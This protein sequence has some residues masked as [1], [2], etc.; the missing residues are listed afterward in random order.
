MNRR[1]FVEAICLGA[2]TTGL[3]GFSN[4]APP[5]SPM[6]EMTSTHQTVLPELVQVPVSVEGVRQPVIDLAGKWQ[7]APDP[8]K[9]FWAH[10]LDRTA[11]TRIT[12]PG[13]FATQGF[14]VAANSEYPS[15]TRISIP[16]DFAGQRILL[17][18]DGV[19][20]RARV[21]VNGSFVRS[22]DGGFTSWTCDITDFAKPGEAAELVVGI[23]DRSDDISQASYYAKHSVA[24]ILRGVRLFAIP[25]DHLT[26]IALTVGLDREYR[27]GRLSITPAVARRTKRPLQLAVRLQDAQGRDIALRQNAFDLNAGNPGPFELSIDNP[28]KW[29]AEH[30]YLYVLDVSLR[31]GT[32]DLMTVRKSIGFR[33][34]ERSGSSLLINGQE[35]KLRGV[36]RHSIHPVYGRTVP[37]D[38]D[39]KDAVLFRQANMNFVRTSH[40]PPSEEFLD[41]CDRH[42]IYVEEET[43]VCWSKCD[44]GPSSDPAFAERFR[45]QWEEMIERDRSHPSVIFWSLGNESQW[46]SNFVLESQCAR[47]LDPSRPTIFS[48]PETVAWEAS[49]FD[50]YSR[51]YAEVNADLS[52]SEFPVL[53]DEFAHV[54]CY[55]IDTLRS[56]SGV[57]NYWGHSIKRFGDRFLASDGC[58]G[59]SIWAGIDEVFLLPEG[60]VGY[61]PWGVIDGWRRPKPEY[62]LTKKAYSPIRIEDG[63]LSVPP[64]GEP[65]RIPVGNAF[66]HTNFSELAIRWSVGSESGKVRN[67]DISPRKRGILNIPP[68]SW[69][70]GETVY[71]QFSRADG[72]LID[73]FNL[74]LDKRRFIFAGPQGPAPQLTENANEISVAG[75][76]FAIG[77]SKQSGLLIHATYRDQKL[78]E[79][80]PFLNLGRGPV[81]RWWLKKLDVRR[82]QD[83]VL[84][85]VS[86]EHIWDGQND[87]IAL[88]YEIAMDGTGLI[89]TTYRTPDKPYNMLGLTYLLPENVDQLTWDRQALWSAYPADHIGR[90]SGVAKK[91]AAHAALRYGEEPTWPWS[92]DTADFFLFGK[93]QPPGATND[94]RSL[95][96]NIWHASCV[97]SGNNARV[98]AESAGDAAVQADVR[99]DGKVLFTIYNCWS[100]P[101]LEWGNYTGVVGQSAESIHSVAIRLT[102]SDEGYKTEF[103]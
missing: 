73:E 23:T 7:F 87:S 33:T 8:V 95:K 67:L 37:S 48:Y 65:L 19:Y 51:H 80:G 54:S 97:L 56:N 29:D 74:P 15:Y 75:S 77:L 9:E 98:R 88:D 43:A 26:R 57:R 62:W 94:F 21:W 100:Y 34:V 35:I 71:L 22:H 101:D 53:N 92:E 91:Q 49:G 31:S 32:A 10:R 102:S 47:E 85:R 24:G 25:Q 50:I 27:N 84:L 61:G 70:S 82:T 2:A 12:V 40:Y 66:D 41:A 14:S 90:A 79:G 45:G 63:A 72:N 5:L 4:S 20:S 17:C 96:E 52:S 30:P 60:P 39:E 59:G 6:N 64:K 28:V 86:G 38:F 1:A 11:W 46:G 99:S 68:R 93:D 83:E 55:N 58:L 81:G 16:Q 13:E 42:G 69:E 36:C 3:T 78:L 103:R 89:R 76:H 18:F 44:N